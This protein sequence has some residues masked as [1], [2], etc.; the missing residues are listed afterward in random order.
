MDLPWS[1]CG[2]STAVCVWEV[3]VGDGHEGEGVEAGGDGV[4]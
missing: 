3:E 2:R 4:D 1:R